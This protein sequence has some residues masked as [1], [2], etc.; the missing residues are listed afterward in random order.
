MVEPTLENLLINKTKPVVK[1]NVVVLMTPKSSQ[2]VTTTKKS[3]S[4]IPKFYCLL[5]LI[6]IFPPAHNY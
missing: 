4:A 5:S 1:R 6:L 2:A 3:N